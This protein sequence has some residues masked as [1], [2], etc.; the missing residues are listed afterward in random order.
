M[1]PPSQSQTG[2]IGQ[3]VR[4]L[5]VPSS[6]SQRCSGVVAQLSGAIAS[7]NDHYLPG[8]EPVADCDVVDQL[9]GIGI[10]GGHHPHA[11]EGVDEQPVD[12]FRLPAEGESLIEVAS[13]S[14]S[15]CPP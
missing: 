7:G 13:D 9:P 1:L 4:G 5:L 15:C 2:S 8:V 10:S 6:E 3:Q 12:V 14:P 11:V